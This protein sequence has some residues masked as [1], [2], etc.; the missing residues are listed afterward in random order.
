MRIEAARSFTPAPGQNLE[1]YADALIARFANTALNHRLSQ[2]AMDGSQKIPQRW[3]ETL[4]VHQA[5]GEPSPALITAL[6]AWVRHVRA[7]ARTVD[8]PRAAEL[9]ELWRT[10]GED[11]VASALFGPSGLFAHIWSADE[12]SLAALTKAVKDR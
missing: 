11:G 6:A 4:A 10:W 8:D 9:A 12:T 5:R 2:I 7:D 3:L 1:A